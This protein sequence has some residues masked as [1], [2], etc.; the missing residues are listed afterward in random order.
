MTGNLPE[1][2][3]LHL[4][5]L[6]A[7]NEKIVFRQSNTKRP[8]ALIGKLWYYWSM[9][10]VASMVALVA[11][12]VM[13]FLGIIRKKHWFYPFCNA[14]ARLWLWLS[15]VKIEVK[16]LENLD[17]NESYVFV[18]NHRSYLDTAV[19]F[20]YTGRKMSIVAKKEL[21]KVPI[22]GYGMQWVNVLPIDRSNKTKAMQ[23]MEEAKNRLHSGYSLGFFAEGTRALPGELLPFKKGAFH[24]AAETGARI[25]PVAMKYSDVLMG[26]KQ[27]YA[28]PGTLEVVF[29]P[30]VAANEKDLEEVR[31]E[32]RAMIAAEL[33]KQA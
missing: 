11:P 31:D 33:E 30:P 26:K 24:M 23:T 14:G 20:C 8:P 22:F 25:V 29:L 12:P 5:E 18:S 3:S 10:A 27:G 19:L 13:L 21:L 15:G 16:G 6:L 7:R 9:F 1:S 2:L 4:S 32:V 28:R 17:P